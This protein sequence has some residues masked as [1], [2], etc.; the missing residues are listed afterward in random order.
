[1]PPPGIRTTRGHGLRPTDSDVAVQ[2]DDRAG[3]ATADFI[4]AE[5]GS[6]RE[7]L[8]RMIAENR[9]GIAELAKGQARIE[10]ILE[11]RLPRD[12]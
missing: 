2:R 11:E 4:R 9:A 3:I 1:M 12:C 10:S 8:R 6:V 7:V 5:I